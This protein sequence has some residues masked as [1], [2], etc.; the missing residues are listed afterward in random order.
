MNARMAVGVALIFCGTLCLLA[1]LGVF[2]FVIHLVFTE[3]LNPF[4]S[5]EAWAVP[6]M[7]FAVLVALGM[8]IAGAVVAVR[9]HKD[10]VH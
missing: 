5:V 1:V 6:F 8:I 7:F 10:R 9:Q 3:D 4:R 2:A